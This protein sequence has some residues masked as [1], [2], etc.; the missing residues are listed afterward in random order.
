MF[1]R[2]KV[3]PPQLQDFDNASFALSLPLDGQSDHGVHDGEL[4][5]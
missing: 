1:A 4:W 3:T 2:A 5:G